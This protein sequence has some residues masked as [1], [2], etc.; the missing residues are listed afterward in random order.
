[1]IISPGTYLRMRR[2]ADGES[3]ESI[4]ALISTEPKLGELDRIEWLHGVEADVVPISEDVI[5][6]LRP[7]FPFDVRVLRRLDAIHRGADLPAPRLCRRCA[8][9]ELDACQPPCSWVGEQDLCSACPVD[10][11]GE[12]AMP[13]EDEG[14][15]APEPDHTQGLA[16]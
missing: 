6:A 13:V 2:E 7:A 9:S 16:A 3:V 14:D 15:N 8:C 1:M 11:P 4:A 10:E 5:A 12:D